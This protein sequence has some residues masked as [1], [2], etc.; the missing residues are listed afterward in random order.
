MRKYWTEETFSYH[1]SVFQLEDVWLTPK[2]V[3]TGG[4][5]IWLA[6]RSAPAITRAARLGDGYMPYMYTA[7]R[8]RAAFEEVHQEAE[9]LGVAL[10]PRFV[11]SAFVYV[12]MDDSPA[13]ARELGIRD[14]SWRYGKDFTPWIDKYCVHG[15]PETCAL[16]LREF[17]DVGIEHLALGMI[18]EESV[19]LDPAPSRG[20]SGRTLATLERY[21]RELLPVLHAAT[22]ARPAA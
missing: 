12:S 18:H 5:P 16:R 3:Q 19:A 6:G 2:P 17:V 7:E 14:L 13:R 21:A 15:T 11:R 22:G 1:G 20:A 9:R 10:S 8:C 4:P